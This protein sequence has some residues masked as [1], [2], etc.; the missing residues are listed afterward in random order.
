MPITRRML[1]ATPA[2]LAMPAIVRAETTTV[3]FYFPVAV[4]G[5]I[6]KAID[7]FAADFIK[8]NP[9]IALK[10]VYAGGYTDTL[11]KAVTAA[12]A[13]Q[14]PQLAV[15]L[16]TDAF[17]LIDD[18]LIVPFDNSADDKAW[19][20]SFYPAFMSNGQIDGQVWGV[21]FQRSS[22]ATV[23]I[24]PKRSESRSTRSMPATI[25]KPWSRR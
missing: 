18:E 24:L 25:P 19:L 21:P 17:S 6:I 12:K 23:R 22:M 1:L 3:E 8:E 9:D 16:S 2:V 10:P 5:P 15:L 11:T 7:G 14:G 20:S 4:G 13:G